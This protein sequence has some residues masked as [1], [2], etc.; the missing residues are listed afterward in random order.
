MQ[1]RHRGAQVPHGDA[2]AGRAQRRAEAV[3]QAEQIRVQLLGHR[4]AEHAPGG[5]RHVFLRRAQRPVRNHDLRAHLGGRDRDLG[6]SERLR[7][8]HVHALGEGAGRDRPELWNLQ[9]VAGA[10]GHAVGAH[11]RL[12]HR[13]VHLR[14][15]RFGDH[16]VDDVFN[17]GA[18]RNRHGLSFHAP[19]GVM[20]VTKA[21]RATELD[22]PAVRGS[23]RR[24]P[25]HQAELLPVMPPVRR[26]PAARK[27]AAPIDRD[28]GAPAPVR[29]GV[30]PPPEARPPPA[31]RPSC[32]GRRPWRTPPG[33]SRAAPGP[34]R[35]P[36]P[37]GCLH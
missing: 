9:R 32:T 36:H 5:A 20:G 7:V 24:R 27:R 28:A 35:G 12:H 2:G 3:Q 4:I 25:G 17:R 16:R 8:R 37:R 6:G 10:A 21:R 18:R 22:G 23:R 31:G 13:A 34:E 19:A 29:T 11:Q 1:P 26:L 30:H 15:A 33:P 14:P